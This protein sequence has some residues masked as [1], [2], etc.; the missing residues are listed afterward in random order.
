MRAK[1]AATGLAAVALAAGAYTVGANQHV[2][3]ATAAQSP[4]VDL[5]QGYTQQLQK[6]RYV[7]L[8]PPITPHTPVWEGFG[9]AKFEPPVNPDTGKPYTYAND[10][11]EATK[12]T[13]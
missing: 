12:Y 10:G 6:G 8:P 1:T 13:I 11:F 2:E 9:P 5:W 4:K 3:R 7:H